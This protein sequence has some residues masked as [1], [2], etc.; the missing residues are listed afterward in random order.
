MNKVK[1]NQLKER[2]QIKKK[3]KSKNKGISKAKHWKKDYLLL[4]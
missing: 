1:R 2:L 3:K 4:T